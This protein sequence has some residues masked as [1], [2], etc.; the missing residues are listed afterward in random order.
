MY[1][2]AYI[3]LY[4][5]NSKISTWNCDKRSSPYRAVNA[6]RLGYTNQSVN[7]VWGNNRCCA[8]IHTKR[9]NTVWAERGMFLLLN[10]VVCEIKGELRLLNCW[11]W[12]KW[13]AMHNISCYF[14]RITSHLGVFE[15]IILLFVLTKS[16]KRKRENYENCLHLE[17]HPTQYYRWEV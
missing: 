12:I 8:E 1:F 5:A 9:M 3:C 17:N 6:V 13:G 2:P 11:F 10:L 7:A 14:D 16:G 4:E 15:S